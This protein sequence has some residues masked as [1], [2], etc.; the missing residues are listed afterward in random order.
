MKNSERIDIPFGR[1]VIARVDAEAEYSPLLTEED[2]EHL[3][4]LAAPARRAQ[5]ST[6]RVILREE[7]GESATLRYA[8]A[9]ALILVSPIGNVRFVSISHSDEWVAVMLSEGRCG[10]DIEAL[11]RNFSRVASRYI[12][13]EE[14]AQFEAQVGDHFEGIMWSAE[15]AIYKY[16]NTSGIDF[17]EDMVITGFDTTQKTITAELYGHATPVVHYHFVGDHILCYLS[18]NQQ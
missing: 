18:D 16:G 3:A 1:I 7:L 8:P 14:R 11:G 6:C 9:G 4:T 2:K 15:E 17:I 10:V 5:W 12:S 13:H